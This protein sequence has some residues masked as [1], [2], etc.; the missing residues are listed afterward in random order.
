VKIFLENLSPAKIGWVQMLNSSAASSPSSGGAR[1]RWLDVKARQ[2]QDRQRYQEP[3]AIPVTRNSS[4]SK[5]SQG[6]IKGSP[7]E[8]NNTY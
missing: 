4:Q 3:F 2:R 7:A 6:I 5:I 1:S 8:G